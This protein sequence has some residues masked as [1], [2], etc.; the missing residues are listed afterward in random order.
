MSWSGENQRRQARRQR[1]CR[2]RGHRGILSLF[3]TWENR[4]AHCP[5]PSIAPSVGV[6]PLGPEPSLINADVP[7]LYLAIVA[8]ISSLPK[9]H[10]V[11]SPY[12]ALVAPFFLQLQ[13]FRIPSGPL[14]GPLVISGETKLPNSLASSVHHFFA[15]FALANAEQPTASQD[16]LLADLEFETS[17]Y[18]Y[19]SLE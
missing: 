7:R 8:A 18:H 2:Q 3:P 12:R 6:P 11:G 1:S 14:R 15:E 4:N 9:G 17:S 10:L 19:Q 16:H 5:A 13:Y